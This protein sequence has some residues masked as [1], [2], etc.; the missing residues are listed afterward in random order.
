[1]GGLGYMCGDWLI[2]MTIDRQKDIGVY[3]YVTYTLTYIIL[4]SIILC[5]CNFRCCPQYI[6]NKAEICFHNFFYAID[7]EMDFGKIL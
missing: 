6:L 7:L 2:D 4:H 3:V 1:M 5:I